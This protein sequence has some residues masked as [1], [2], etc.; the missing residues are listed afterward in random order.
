MSVRASTEVR[1]GSRK[2]MGVTVN[3]YTKKW[4]VKIAT[5]LQLCNRHP[6]M[7]SYWKHILKYW[8]LC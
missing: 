2:S 5:F 7:A 4:D 1:R 6:Q 8:S 3:V